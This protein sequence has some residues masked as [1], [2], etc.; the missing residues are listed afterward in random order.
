MRCRLIID[1]HVKARVS[2][3][4]GYGASHPRPTPPGPHRVSSITAAT[5]AAA[6]AGSDW[7]RTGPP[8]LLDTS[9]TECWI[10]VASRAKTQDHPVASRRVLAHSVPLG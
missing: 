8:G 9:S 10:Q 6:T 4:A 7:Q 1:V 2:F 5:T 3:Y